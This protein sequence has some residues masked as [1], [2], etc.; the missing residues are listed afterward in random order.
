[1][2][3]YLLV[4]IAILSKSILIIINQVLRKTKIAVRIS[5]RK[6]H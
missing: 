3:T 6:G 5:S 4:D 2:K 1:M